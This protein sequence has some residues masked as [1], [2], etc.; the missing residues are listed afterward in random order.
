MYACI[1]DALLMQPVDI[2]DYEDLHAFPI[3][4]PESTAD[5]DEDHAFARQRLQG[6]YLNSCK[7]RVRSTPAHV[8]KGLDAHCVSGIPTQ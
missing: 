3:K 5:F 7:I 2:N 8:F 4:T 6:M 1:D